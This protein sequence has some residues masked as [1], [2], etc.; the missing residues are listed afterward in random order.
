MAAADRAITDFEFG[1]QRLTDGR[2]LAHAAVARSGEA[3]NLVANHPK[4]AALAD[5]AGRTVEDVARAAFPPTRASTMQERV[6]GLF[7]KD[8]DAPT[9]P[10]SSRGR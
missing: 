2:T 10:R 6:L 4:I 7:S 3:A 1:S 9:R 8:R 5:T